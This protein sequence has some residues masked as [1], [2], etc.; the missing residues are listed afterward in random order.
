MAI[1]PS[2]ILLNL[3]HELEE[4]K[5]YINIL[6]QEYH[7]VSAKSPLKQEIA[8]LIENLNQFVLPIEKQ[9]Q[10]T[11]QL[12]L[13]IGFDSHTPDRDNV[14]HGLLDELTQ[15]GITTGKVSDTKLTDQAF[16][17]LQSIRVKITKNSGKRSKVKANTTYPLQAFRSKEIYF[18]D[19]SQYTA[20]QTLTGKSALKIQ[21]NQ[22]GH[23]V[24]VSK[25]EK[26]RLMYQPTE[27]PVPMESPGLLQKKKKFH[28]DFN[29][30]SQ[31]PLAMI[32][33]LEKQD[34][35]IQSLTLANFE[36][37]AEKEIFDKICRARNSV[38]SEINTITQQIKDKKQ[39]SLWLSFY[40][41][42]LIHV[43]NALNLWL[44]NILLPVYPPLLPHEKDAEQAL[45]Y[46]QAVSRLVNDVSLS[47]IFSVQYLQALQF[48]IG[49]TEEQLKG[50]AT[51][52]LVS[53]YNTM[54]A[55]V[56]AKQDDKDIFSPRVMS[57]PLK[58]PMLYRLFVTETF[59]FDW[60]KTQQPLLAKL[61]A[62]G[63]KRALSQ[64]LSRSDLRITSEIENAISAITQK[65]AENKGLLAWRKRVILN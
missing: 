1:I 57:A 32:Y 41:N 17:D 65:I 53:Q 43:N 11:L 35:S 49:E 45:K 56:H 28:F 10:K 8:R 60:L 58:R 55:I 42:K 6:T 22:E 2:K 26:G 15:L 59:H 21:K 46:Y 13:A 63:T 5:A 19:Q 36:K 47:G 31:L 44:K 54:S 20:L 51:K 14:V 52:K 40:N 64:P 50:F 27:I 9:L 62:L 39:L 3:H 38:L 33:A 25:T 37:T 34:F 7:S 16:D 29:Q 24:I 30:Q 48:R 18:L 23:S 4:I 12:R 61:Y